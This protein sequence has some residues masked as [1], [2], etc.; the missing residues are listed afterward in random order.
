MS[1]VMVGAQNENSVSWGW[2]QV[3]FITVTFTQIPLGKIWIN[4]FFSQL[5]VKYEIR[6][7][8]LAMVGNQLRRKTTLNS[9][10]SHLKL[11][12]DAYAQGTDIVC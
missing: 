6:L 3:K 7:G 8:S 5:W 12:K 10:L 11:Y 4:L 2:I 9:M 1:F